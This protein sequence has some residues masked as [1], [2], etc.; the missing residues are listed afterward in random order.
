MAKPAVI[1]V[2]RLVFYLEGYLHELKLPK[3]AT[4]IEKQKLEIAK[5]CATLLKETF[6]A[7]FPPKP[8]CKTPW[9]GA[10]F[11]WHC[12]TPWMGGRPVFSEPLARS[13]RK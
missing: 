3:D 12:K 13:R 9:Y 1:K 11:L 8:G 2:N 5:L 7:P 6:M 10:N 4:K